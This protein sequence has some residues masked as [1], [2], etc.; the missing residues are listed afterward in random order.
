M[1]RR[2]VW[3]HAQRAC[4][5]T[6]KCD[7]VHIRQAHTR[8]QLPVMFIRPSKM[9]WRGFCSTCLPLVDFPGRFG[10]QIRTQHAQSYRLHT[11]KSLRLEIGASNLKIE[12]WDW[13]WTKISFLK[14]KERQWKHRKHRET[15][16]AH[17]GLSPFVLLLVSIIPISLIPVSYTHLTLPTI[18]L[19]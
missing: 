18:L 16:P 17:S 19:V 13:C 3:S 1:I 11:W 5:R 2:M 7:W 15:L 8:R 4:I 6:C 10:P 14:N 9:I 12:D